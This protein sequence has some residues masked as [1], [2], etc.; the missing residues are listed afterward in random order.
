[1]CSSDLVLAVAV[2]LVVGLGVI[3]GCASST[4][5]TAADIATSG[6]TAARDGSTLVWGVTVANA[7][8]READ[9]RLQI[10]VSVEGSPTAFY[11]S[12]ERAE[13]L[14]GGETKTY[15]Y[16]ET[17]VPFPAGSARLEFAVSVAAVP[18]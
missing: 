16:T 2:A 9:L 17:G 5:F 8:S 11:T 15:L 1:V 10:R 7:S 6:A 3:G 14:G 13:T 18:N 12:P 4:G